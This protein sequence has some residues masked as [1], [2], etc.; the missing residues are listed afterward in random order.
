MATLLAS[1]LERFRPLLRLQVRQMQLD[2]RLQKRFDSSDLVQAT[3]QRALENLANFRGGSEGELV[4]WL[5]EILGSTVV[6]EIRKAR[7]QKRDVTLERSLQ[8]VVA[9]SSARLEKFLA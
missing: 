1:D 8:A 2:P 7:A 6:D 4:Q 5:H 9:E 3:F